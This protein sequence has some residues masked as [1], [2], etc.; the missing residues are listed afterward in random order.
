MRSIALKMLTGDRGKYLGII[1]GLAFASFLITQQMAIFMGLMTRTYGFITDAGLAD[2]WVMDAK[3]DFVD[4]IKPLQ[5]TQLYRVRGVEGVEWAVPLYRGFLRTRMENGS[6]QTCIIVG[7]DDA[8]L[9]GGPATMLEGRLE[10][11]RRNEGV[12]VDES[13]ARGHLAHPPEVP[14]GPRRPLRVGDFLEINDH[15]GIVV[16]LCRASRT[17]MA[18]P[19]LYTTY[20]RATAFAPHERKLLSFVL[21]KGKPGTDAEALCRRIG[22]VTG[23]KALPRARFE[24]DTV[25]YW[26][27]NTGIPINFGMAV[28]LGFIVGTA[29]AGQTF[30]NFTAE[31]L[32][33]FAALKAM[34]ATNARLFG[35][36]ALQALVVGAIGL[37]LG[38]GAAALFGRLTS[39]TN[40]AF[41][42]PWQ[43]LAS[44]VGA[45]AV[46]VVFA[47]FLSIRKVMKL[48]P[49]M[50]FKS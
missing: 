13:A 26:M 31:N 37:G 2:V 22:A 4:D 19:L 33:H 32:R 1:F 5:D 44:A 8:T 6:F 40:L 9:I 49:A 29:I 17:L 43:V 18:N 12:I 15:R 23:L 34:G 39:G 11:L 25:M 30:Y 3:V 16:G 21:V 38:V 24:D 41:R 48:E 35:M 14:G 46:I 50:V 10:D 47:A 45:I 20:S 27:R 36:V 42:L 28:V 7:L